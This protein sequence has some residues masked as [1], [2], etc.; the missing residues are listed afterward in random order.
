MTIVPK[1]VMIIVYDVV[2]VGYQ[3]RN[4]IKKLRCAILVALN[5]L[6]VEIHS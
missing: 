5:Q 4:K 2:G 3:L 1:K 6:N